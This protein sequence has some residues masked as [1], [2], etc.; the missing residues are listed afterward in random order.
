MICAVM[1]GCSS[2]KDSQFTSALYAKS[3]HK[4]GRM[5]PQMKEIIEDFDLKT[6]ELEAIADFFLKQLF[7]DLKRI[8]KL[9]FL[10]REELLSTIVL[11]V[12]DKKKRTACIKMSG[13]GLFA[14]NKK[15]TE[16]DHNNVPNFLG[17]HLDKPYE[18]VKAREI[19][20]WTFNEVRDI[21]ISTDGID[22][23]KPL[24]K[25]NSNVLNP[26]LKLLIEQPNNMGVSFLENQY[27]HLKDKGLVPLDDIGVIRL[28]SE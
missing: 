8:K 7:E 9:F 24:N 22:K 26:R 14:V 27:Q 23:L 28:I 17:Y 19:Q 15:I 21:S 4:S 13:D 16:V 11:L 5:L 6:I 12:I 1:D 20:T 10:K 18:E 25:K 3:L 2:A